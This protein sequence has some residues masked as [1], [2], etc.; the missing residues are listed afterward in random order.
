MADLQRQLKND[1]G[2]IDAP[3]SAQLR[4]RIDAALAAAER[5]PPS[6]VGVVRSPAFHWASALLGVAGAAALIAVLG[7]APQ[8]A[9]AA[10]SAAVP[11]YTARI[12]GPIP[13]NLRQVEL[14]DPLQAELVSLR[15]DAEKV[16]RT[17]ERDLGVNL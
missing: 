15:A 16:R 5:Q 13:L 11:A 17:V 8:E 7:R 12:A 14:T 1:A 6:R 9:P 10:R 2:D 4:R 3:V